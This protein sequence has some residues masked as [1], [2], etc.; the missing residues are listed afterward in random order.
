MGDGDKPSAIGP[1]HA[2]TMHRHF[3]PLYKGRATLGILGA[4]H[5][6]APAP[7]L[8]RVKPGHTSESINGAGVRL[9]ATPQV[10]WPE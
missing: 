6:F 2:D 5:L 8:S 9:C 3:K 1:G 7:L 10:A 4:Q